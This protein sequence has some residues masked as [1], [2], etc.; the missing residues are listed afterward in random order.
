MKKTT[1]DEALAYIAKNIPVFPCAA[2]KR[3][4]TTHGFQ[5]AST[6]PKQVEQ[7]FTKFPHADIGIP[8]GK[9]SGL[10]TLDLDVKNGK[11]GYDKVPDWESLSRLR[12]RTPSGGAQVFFKHEPGIPSQNNGDYEV[13]SD[14]TY[15]IVPAPDSGRTWLDLELPD[16]FD[17]LPP[18]AAARK[19][20]IEKDP[21]VA[22]KPTPDWL[23]LRLSDGLAVGLG[24]SNNP[25]DLPM[26]T[27]DEDVLLALGHINPHELSYMD[28]ASVGGALYDHFGEA[29]Y[30]HFE[31]WSD[32]SREKYGTQS[33]SPRRQW[34][35]CRTMTAFHVGTIFHF[36]D[37]QGQDWRSNREVPEPK[38]E[39][40]ST[41]P[42][43]IVEPEAE[44][45][46]EETSTWPVLHADAM[47]GPAWEIVKL[48]EPDTE[49]DPIAIYFQLLVAF[50]NAVG[51]D[52]YY[53]IEGD[54]HHCNE[55]V[56]VAGETSRGRKGT[57][58]GRV[59]EVIDTL[60]E[61][62]A[63]TCARGG[64]SSGEG[65][66][67][68]VRDPMTKRDKDGNEV[69]IDEGAPS[70]NFCALETEFAQLLSVMERQGN[71]ISPIFRN[72]WDGTTLRTM[73]RQ[74]PLKATNAHVSCVGHITISELKSKLTATE[75]ASG[76]GNRILFVVVRR[77]KEL[78][79][80]GR[81]TVEIEQFVGSI[82]GQLNKSIGLC[83]RERIGA[84]FA[85][86]MTEAS[87]ELWA[88]GMYSK[89][90]AD[91]PGLLGSLVS[92]SEAH[93]IRLAMILALF[94]GNR[95][96]DVSHLRA[97]FAL[98][99]YVHDS[100]KFIFGYS[101]GD[102][103]ADRINEALQSVYP[104]GMTR[105]SISVLFGKNLPSSVL[106]QA[107]QKLLKL[108]WASPTG[109]KGKSGGE[110]WFWVPISKRRR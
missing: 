51:R 14:G 81:N 44:H 100:A 107:L 35:G 69:V 78:P 64:L 18:F 99:T 109:S 46:V 3:P 4:L 72:A 63:E 26:D 108:D 103:V 12:M 54:Q 89:L 8:L 56:C 67:N 96:I 82:K 36:A 88:G 5:D 39:E 105:T 59:R 85:V 22:V 28:W 62:W 90:T 41:Q 34:R 50:G 60:F 43:K 2:N 42:P 52:F 104:Q 23:L 7:W 80:G 86:T 65:L 66:I 95:M 45:E 27:S 11:K 21:V 61:G 84:P 92:R 97:A 49:A 33:Q 79:F 20:V 29:G 55:Y 75:A 68:Q 87:R 106:G 53:R 102:P 74:S 40:P 17:A 13:K 10:A 31:K 30:K 32:W 37:K 19:Y 24:V 83:G 94:E 15:T 76:F 101:L 38:D 25:D 9:I 6:D 47:R 73:T 71:T 93:T 91:V 16:A 58:W 57:S 1:L 77:S 98:V 48:I 110:S 70:K